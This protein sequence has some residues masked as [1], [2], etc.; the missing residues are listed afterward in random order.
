M[1]GRPKYAAATEVPPGRSRDEIEQTVSRFGAS[2]FAYG[3]EGDT[4]VVGFK[5]GQWQYRF[6][7]A[8]PSP[9]DD[10]FWKSPTGRRRSA[11]AAHE[12]YAQATRQRWRA[13]A[14]LVKAK[15]AAVEAGITT[16]DEEFLPHIVLPGGQTVAQQALPAVARA[17]ATGEVASLFAL[18]AGGDQ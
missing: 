17:Y 16:V 3:Y 2:S 6:T 8:L 15:F 11:T 1:T 9:G 4:A 5:L 14:L 12:A 7:V 10:L 13:L 18:P